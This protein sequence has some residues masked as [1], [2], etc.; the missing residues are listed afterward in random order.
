MGTDRLPFELVQPH[1]LSRTQVTERARRV[2]RQQQ[3]DGGGPVEAAEAVEGCTLPDPSAVPRSFYVRASRS[4]RRPM[5]LP[6]MTTAP[7]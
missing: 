2:E 4:P 5:R 1:A 6:D 3:V 7:N